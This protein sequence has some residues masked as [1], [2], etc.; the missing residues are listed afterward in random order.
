[1]K[2][3]VLELSNLIRCIIRHLNLESLRKRKVNKMV[4]LLSNL[5]TPGD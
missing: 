4:V 1:M 3:F 5:N 2:L